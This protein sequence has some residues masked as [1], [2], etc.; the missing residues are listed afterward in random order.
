WHVIHAVVGATL[1]IVA[2]CNED[3]L[4]PCKAIPNLQI[5]SG[6]VSWYKIGGNGEELKSL[7][8]NMEQSHSRVLNESLETSNDTQHSLKIENITSYS[9][10]TYKCILR[11]SDRTYNKS[12]AITLKVIGCPDQSQDAKF[13]KYR[14]ELALLCSL[15]GFYLLLIIFAC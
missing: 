4:L 7:Q 9:S 12:T 15:G 5:T 13:Q 1:Q 11:T 6:V 10:G 3:V 2:T 8:R 14:T